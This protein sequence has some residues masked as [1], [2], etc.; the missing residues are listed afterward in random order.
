MGDLKIKKVCGFNVSSIHFS[1]MILPYINKE[2]EKEKD[3]ITILE[4]NLEKNIKQVLS[5]ITIANE[6]K[7]KILDIGWSATDI[8]RINIEKKLKT[9]ITEEKNIDVI[10]YGCEKFIIEVNKKIEEYLKKHKKNMENVYIKI[11][12][13]YFV[14]DFNENIKEI[15]DTHDVMFNTSGEHKI[16]EVF[17]GYHLA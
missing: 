12:D 15:L 2:L 13:S 14:N 1:M 9:K 11:I 7:E 5:K 16:E 8:K 17:D 3:I 10:V 4:G 6:E